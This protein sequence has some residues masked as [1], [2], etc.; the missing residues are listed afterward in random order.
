MAGSR[1]VLIGVSAYRNMPGLPAVTADVRDLGGLLTDPELGGLPVEHLTVVENPESSTDLL[2]PVTEAARHAT[3]L[4]VVYFAGHGLL[5]DDGELY[6]ALPGGNRDRMA[7][8][9]RFGDLRR[10]VVT[11]ARRCRAK[12][13]VLDCCFSGRAIGRFM[14]PGGRL[15]ALAGVE[16]AYVM[17]ATAGTVA[18]LA[19]PDEKYTA[20]T[21]ELIETLRDGVPGAPAVLDT[22]TVFEAVEQRLRVKGR[23]LP[24]RGSRD[25]GHRIPLV[26]NRASHLPAPAE[27]PLA[28]RLWPRL[29]RWWPALAAATVGLA[30]TPVLIM[31]GEDRDQ[32]SAPQ[33]DSTALPASAGASTGAASTSTSPSP[34]L[35]PPIVDNLTATVEGPLVSTR[36]GVVEILATDASS[37]IGYNVI[38]PETTCRVEAPGPNRSTV[39]LRS[40]KPMRWIRIVMVRV[41]MG[42]EQ[43]DGSSS[44]PMDFKVEQ[45]TGPAPQGSDPCKP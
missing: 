37:I 28:P 23:P 29:R 27:A 2:A 6:L 20:F 26:R 11:T 30:L 19:P 17:T 25:A 38:T 33:A 9:V 34:T 39:I 4:L 41:R 44:L 7:Y 18:A 43:A 45:G 42:P 22:D 13:V 21:G 12:V 5:D 8:A 31:Q 3:D 40:A 24:Q 10:E 32:G 15:A 36:N 35:P 16:G 14:G 1:A